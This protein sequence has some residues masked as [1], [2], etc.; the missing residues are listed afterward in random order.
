MNF[1]KQIL[2]VLTLLILIISCSD[3]ESPQ[4]QEIIQS[5]DNESQQPQETIQ[6]G[7]KDLQGLILEYNGVES[8]TSI[9]NT[10]VINITEF[11]FLAQVIR[12][13]TTPAKAGC[14]ELASR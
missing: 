3:N 10:S 8:S 5:G 2:S 11:P 9:S 7:D 12:G 14:T 1:K 6:S 13:A 4:P